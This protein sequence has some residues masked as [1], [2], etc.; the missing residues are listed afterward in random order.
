[1]GVCFNDLITKVLHADEHDDCGGVVTISGAFR[2]C[3][4]GGMDDVIDLI[5]EYHRKVDA[6][7]LA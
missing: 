5:D 2:R 7:L 4:R 6:L 3:I 1:M